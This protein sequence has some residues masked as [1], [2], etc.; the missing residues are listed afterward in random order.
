M[1]AG[2]SESDSATFANW[3][4]GTTERI[5]HLPAR[6]QNLSSI[7]VEANG[8]ES[9]PVELCVLYDGRP[10][11]RIAFDEGNESHIINSSDDD[12]NDCRCTE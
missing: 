4:E 1:S 7:Y 6:L 8:S 9:N 12:D 10:K 11:K 2:A 5:F 3:K